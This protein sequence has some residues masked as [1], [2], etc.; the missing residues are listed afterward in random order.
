MSSLQVVLSPNFAPAAM[1]N[2]GLIV[3]RGE[4]MMISEGAD[5]DLQRRVAYVLSH[6]IAHQWFGNL[7]TN[8][9]WSDVYIQEGLATYFGLDSNIVMIFRYKCVEAGY[10]ELQAIDAFT[11]NDIQAYYAYDT[12][13]FSVPIKPQGLSG[14]EAVNSFSAISYT[15]VITRYTFYARVR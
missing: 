2:Y 10:P 3:C 8:Q 6:E 9:D 12:F 4:Y 15:K 5:Q 7:V 1:E 11:I 14:I 13:N